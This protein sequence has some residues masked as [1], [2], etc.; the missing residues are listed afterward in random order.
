MQTKPP[1]TSTQALTQSTL[2]LREGER[3]SIGAVLVTVQRIE[4]EIVAISIAGDR[5]PTSYRCRAGRHVKAQSVGA[6]ITV[7][8]IGAGGRKRVKLVIDHEVTRFPVMGR[9]VQRRLI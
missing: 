1:A 6:A 5:P 8:E 2:T 7:D 3:F 4:E 9:R